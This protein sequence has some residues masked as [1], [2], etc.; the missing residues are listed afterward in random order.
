MEKNK[1][2]EFSK[3]LPSSYSSVSLLV[4]DEAESNES[5]LGLTWQS[6]L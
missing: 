3:D 6:I 4:F 1:I 5:P 2:N